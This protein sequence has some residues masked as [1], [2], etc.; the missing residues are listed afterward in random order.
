M[1]YL[2]TTPQVH[3]PAWERFLSHLATGHLAALPVGPATALET[4]RRH[5]RQ[6]GLAAALAAATIVAVA[7]VMLG[8]VL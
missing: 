1:A 5:A 4:R 3:R 8:T 6:M 2:E 7:G